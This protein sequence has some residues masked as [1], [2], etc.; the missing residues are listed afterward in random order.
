[1]SPTPSESVAML[2]ELKLLN[3]NF[4]SA[5]LCRC[6]LVKKGL[7]KPHPNISHQKFLSVT[8]GIISY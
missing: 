8:L 2:S 1:M 3:A 5:K 6:L 7:Y 4:E